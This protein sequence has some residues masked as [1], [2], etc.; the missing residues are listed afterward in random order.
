MLPSTLQHLLT[1]A[2]T[3]RCHETPS[4]TSQHFSTT[5]PHTGCIKRFS[6]AEKRT[7]NA[8]KTANLVSKFCA[9]ES[10]IG[11]E[12]FLT[13]HSLFSENSD[14]R[15]TLQATKFTKGIH[16]HHSIFCTVF[17]LRKLFCA[18]CVTSLPSNLAVPQDLVTVQLLPSVGT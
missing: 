9:L 11:V 7:E 18:P 3:F 12:N 16:N 14:F 17:R 1:L 2:G 5:F 10:I 15:Y 6:E 4:N 13:C 8:M